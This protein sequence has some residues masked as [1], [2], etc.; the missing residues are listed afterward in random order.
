MRGGWEG[1]GGETNRKGL[2]RRP[3]PIGEAEVQECK[4][5]GG[6]LT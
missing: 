2:H 1:Q 5:P 4:L 6:R 3:S